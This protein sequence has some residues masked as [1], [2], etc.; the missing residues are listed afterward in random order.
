MLVQR[1]DNLRKDLGY[2]V[3]LLTIIFIINESEIREVWEFKCEHFNQNVLIFKE[4]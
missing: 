1:H 2:H 3:Y 4:T